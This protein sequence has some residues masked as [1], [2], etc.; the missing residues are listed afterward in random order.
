[1]NDKQEVV[2]TWLSDVH[3]PGLRRAAGKMPGGR[4]RLVAWHCLSLETTYVDMV[5]R[6]LSAAPPWAAMLADGRLAGA[7]Y[8]CLDDLPALPPGV[9]GV[10]IGPEAAGLLGG[11]LRLAGCFA[12][13]TTPLVFP[14]FDASLN[15]DADLSLHRGRGEH[16][17][18]T[19][20]EIDLAFEFSRRFGVVLTA[21]PS[22]T[23]TG[24]PMPPEQ[25]RAYMDRPGMHRLVPLYVC[26]AIGRWHDDERSQ[27][28]TGA[29]VLE[30]LERPTR[31]QTTFSAAVWRSGIA[32]LAAPMTLLSLQ[33]VR[34]RY[35]LEPL[36]THGG[37]SS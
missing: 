34:V 17:S 35:G 5:L 37:G 25:K 18:R 28:L 6:G 13:I 8:H 21:H 3:S 11:D 10:R 26:G 31:E 16:D 1:M 29:W 27:R 15:L 2:Q 19:E 12:K 32:P 30:F 4:R 9:F 33:A 20:T 7:I 23:W 24:E 22:S 14:E 36:A